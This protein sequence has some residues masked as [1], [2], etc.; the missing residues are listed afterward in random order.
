MAAG[1]GSWCLE[2]REVLRELTVPGL[3]IYNGR[4]RKAGDWGS[5]KTR[6]GGQKSQE[7]ELGVNNPLKEERRGPAPKLL[8]CNCRVGRAS[9][10]NWCLLEPSMSDLSAFKE[11]T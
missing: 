8:Y 6:F 7:T 10:F 4:Q 11:E 5:N 9:S 2:F 1:Q 3:H